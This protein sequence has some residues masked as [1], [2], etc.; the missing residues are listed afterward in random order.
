VYAIAAGYEDVNDH[1]FLRKDTCF[2]TAAGRDEILA[3]ESTLSRS[4]NTILR[5]TLPWL[6][7]RTLIFANACFLRRSLVNQLFKALQY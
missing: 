1:E 7:Q 2:Q 4:E 6:L 5:A 3:S